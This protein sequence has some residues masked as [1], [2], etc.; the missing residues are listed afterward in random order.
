MQRLLFQ[1]QVP[2]TLGSATV[3]CLKYSV[4]DADKRKKK[5][6]KKKSKISGVKA[7][8]QHLICLQRGVSFCRVVSV[9]TIRKS[10]HREGWIG[11]DGNT[12]GIASHDCT[13]LFFF[14][15]NFQTHT[16]NTHKQKVQAA[17]VSALTS[18]LQNESDLQAF[19]LRAQTLSEN[20][21]D[22]IAELDF[23]LELIS[24]EFTTNQRQFYFVS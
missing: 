18:L 17:A 16:N 7:S 8:A 11:C 2:I 10:A 3:Q 1:C 5:M 19:V 6:K 24:K 9:Q 20:G 13:Y 15:S 14:D 22:P 23:T 21:L 4:R 12:L